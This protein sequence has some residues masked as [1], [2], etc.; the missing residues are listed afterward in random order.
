M[1][2]SNPLLAKSSFERV[3]AHL[4]FETVTD[5]GLCSDDQDLADRFVFEFPE[6]HP[7]FLKE[8]DEMFAGDAA[9]PENRRMR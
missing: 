7:V 6:R 5:A 2:A 8:P 4:V 9:G 1:P 3:A